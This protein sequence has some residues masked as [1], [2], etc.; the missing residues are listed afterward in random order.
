MA[1]EPRRSGRATKGQH[2]KD[3]DVTED[4]TAP[5]TKKKG[6][7]KGAKAKV[8]EEE[9]EE[10]EEVIR[11][12]CG[13][14]A[15][16][17]DEP[18]AMICCDNC[19]AWQHNSCMGLPEDYE[20]E[21]YF[22]EQCKPENHKKLV[23]AIAK[24]EKPWEEAIKQREQALA[25]K[26]KKKGGRKGRKSAGA[27][28]EDVIASASQEPQE[29]ELKPTPA[30]TPAPTPAVTSGQKRKLEES[31]SVPEIKNKKARAT[32]SAETNGSKPEPSRDG[33][34]SLPEPPSRQASRS[35][36]AGGA[37][38]V[39]DVKE[40][41]NS[42]RKSGATSLIKLI[43]S[44]IKDAVKQKEYSIPPKTS[45]MEVAT[46]IGLQV[47]HA[48]Y[49]IQAGGTGD[50]NEAYKIQLRAV[51][52]N[53]KKNHALGVRLLTG[54][55]DPNVLAGMDPK[56]MASEEQKRKDA[57]VLK[58]M[59]KQHT[60]IEQEGP[61]IRRTH[62]GDEY[63][64]ESRQV[65]KESTTSNATAAKQT[66]TD[67][68]GQVKSPEPK[69][70]SPSLSGP[71]RKASSQG[72][73]SVDST[74]RQSSTNFDIDRVFANVAGSPTT[75]G[76][77]DGPR[78]GELP[79]QQPDPA[80]PGTKA[81]ADIDELLKD[82]EAE[83]PPYSPKDSSEEDGVV[84][85]GS[86]NGGSLGK[87]NIVAKY[88][89]GAT[90]ESDTLRLT[91]HQL[92]SDQVVIAGRIQPSKAEAYLCG[93]EYSSTSDLVIVYMPEPAE[94]SPD[95]PQFV[96]FFNYFKTKERFGVG[97]QSSI[98]AV[99]DIYLV[100]LDQGQ[101]LPTFV[102]KIE[103]NFPDPTTQRMLLVP[104][105]VKNSEL[106]HN[107]AQ[108]AMNSPAGAVAQTP[109]T[110]MDG[111]FDHSH[112]NNPYGQAPSLPPT[113]NGVNGTP[114][115]YPGAPPHA[116]FVPPPQQQQYPSAAVLNAQRV[117]GTL[118]TAP[119][120]VQLCEQVPSAGEHEFVIVKECIE[121][122]PEAG[123]RLDVLTKMLQDVQNIRQGK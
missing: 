76:D 38:I 49:H 122:N 70:K 58:E 66:A 121:R 43:D 33:K 37:P 3:R 104:I 101:E 34:P 87:F 52:F 57:Q 35:E 118:A 113:G 68:D 4:A 88:A 24:G 84:W 46:Q 69:I 86:V 50:P 12:V 11:C 91:Y 17:E 39:S 61:R 55:L 14:Y 28:T 67:E 13:T 53:V 44:L 80:G 109:I 73:P 94:G 41:T 95:H 105:V 99:K 110:P 65:A 19:A 31:P 116:Q 8:V 48:L 30:T 26:A 85:R 21:K 123:R 29:P 97:V 119:A 102:K 22:C 36:P 51:T 115:P 96:K 15:E 83:S 25:E 27:K 45:A 100:P 103:H 56:D 40:L 111:T 6:K 98:P 18:R 77:P 71:N 112:P 32:S 10:Q 47:E 64:D 93:L 20:A 60:I 90:P 1:D 89:A 74:R 59:E 9:E 117:L 54:E 79:A 107:Q 23:A 82:E 7:G 63:V 2:N 78:F 42:S 108:G 120:V 62:K 106:P 92:L 81:D 5:N 72:R 16:E 75:G 114:S